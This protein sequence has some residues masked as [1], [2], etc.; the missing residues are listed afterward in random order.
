M[1]S[2]PSGPP[3]ATT[4]L[5]APVLICVAVVAG[6][7]D[8]EQASAGSGVDIEEAESRISDAGHGECGSRSWQ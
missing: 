7:E 2:S 3:I 1:S 6:G 4:S 8:G 5:P